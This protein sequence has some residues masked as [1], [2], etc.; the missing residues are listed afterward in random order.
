MSSSSSITKSPRHFRDE[1]RFEEQLR[2]GVVDLGE[3]RVRVGH[4]IRE[5]EIANHV[6][7][8]QLPAGH[9]A[10]GQERPRAEVGGPSA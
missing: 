4:V 8:R 3:P 2:F 5:R 7:K 6:E 9:V 10:G 1:R